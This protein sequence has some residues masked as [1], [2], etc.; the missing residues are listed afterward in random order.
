MAAGPRTVTAGL[1][2]LL[3]L[4]ARKTRKLALLQKT[5]GPEEAEPI[6]KPLPLFLTSSYRGE[7]RCLWAP[8]VKT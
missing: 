6:T 2:L 8:T 3:S 5:T 7:Q 4:T 1:L